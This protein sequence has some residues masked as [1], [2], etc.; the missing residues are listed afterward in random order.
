MTKPGLYINWRKDCLPE[1]LGVGFS[2]Q[3]N[4]AGAL[5]ICN[6][7]GSIKGII[8][9]GHWISAWVVEEEKKESR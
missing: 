8:A 5:I 1:N 7:D 9:S 2:I 4:E 3:T 6:S